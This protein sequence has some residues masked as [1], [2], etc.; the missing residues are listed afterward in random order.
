[1]D[2]LSIPFLTFRVGSYTYALRIEE[3]LEV[4]G[5]VETIP[6]A[7]APLALVGVVNR[8][9]EVIPLLDLKQI[10]TQIRSTIT[11]NTLFIVAKSGQNQFGLVVDEVYQ[12]KY[13]SP[14]DFQVVVGGV[15][16]QQAFTDWQGFNQILSLTPI[17]ARHIHE[18]DKEQA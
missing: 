7:S 4:V 13:I 10:L 12:V 14:S 16:C 18:V 17:I 5:M 6:I 1:M 11:S 3:V 15:Y 9:G 2:T 8:H